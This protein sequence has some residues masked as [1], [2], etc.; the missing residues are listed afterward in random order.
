MRVLKEIGMLSGAGIAKP[1]AKSIICAK[2]NWLRAPVGGLLRN[3][4]AEGDVVEEGDI[5]AAISDP[6]GDGEIEVETRYG[7]IIVG[8]A[9]MPVVHECDALFHIAA[10]KSADAAEAAIDGL[11]SQLEAD[12]LFDEDEII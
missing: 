4:K 6:F 5:V 8:R 7:G 12:P 1:K 10:V 9:L 11:A 2:S 3:F